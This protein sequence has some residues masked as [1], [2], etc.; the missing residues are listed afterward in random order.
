MVNAHIA[1]YLFLAGMGGGAFLIGA[2]VDVALR[3]RSSAPLE[4][5]SAVTDRGLI[6]GPLAVAVGL[7]F[8][9]ADLGSPERALRLFLAPPNGILGWG[10]WGIALFLVTSVLAYILGQP[11]RP[12]ALRVAEMACHGIA[13]LLA[14]FVITYSG[15]YLSLFPTVPFLNHPLV[16]ILFVVSALST[17]MALLLACDFVLGDA[18]NR[19][20]RTS[21]C[22]KTELVLIASDL[23]ALATLLVASWFGTAEARLSVEA[24]I[25]GPYAVL[26]WF[27][28][29]CVGLAAPLL[30][31][32]YHRINP[33]SPSYAIG[34]ACTVAGGLCLRYAL[35]QAAIRFSAFGM[36]AVTFWG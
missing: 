15:V 8:L 32:V 29:L 20:T 22:V 3:L 6:F 4:N 18:K 30:L 24:L 12:R 28:V 33:N 31:G 1:W 27:G 35:L 34:A 14:A 21:P 23:A 2:V 11:N 9:L 25:I 17:G 26:F 10:A 5:A 36:E 13:T 16:P 19:G 7:V